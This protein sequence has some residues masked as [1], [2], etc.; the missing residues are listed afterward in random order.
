MTER[1]LVLVAVHLTVL[2]GGFDAWCLQRGHARPSVAELA[3]RLAV[4]PRQVEVEA[5]QQE[6]SAAVQNEKRLIELYVRERL[7]EVFGAEVRAEIAQ[8]VEEMVA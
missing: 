8:Q 7:V 2:T 3:G 6:I 5:L 1:E 4:Y